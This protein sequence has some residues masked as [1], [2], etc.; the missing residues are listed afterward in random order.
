MTADHRPE[1]V[2]ARLG[3][4]LPEVAPD[5]YYANYRRSAAGPIHLSGQLPSVDGEVRTLG[6]LGKEV[7]V[8]TARE[9]MKI[10]TINALAVAAEA[11]GGLDNL[12][13]LQL[14]VFVASTP[15]FKGQSDVADAGSA[16]LVEI[17]GEHGRH[18]RTAF[19]VSSLPRT[20]PLEVQLIVEARS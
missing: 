5:S 3:I 17:L 9:L 4:E 12:R 20:S 16:L 8:E 6:S 2:L 19:G 7:D 14:L 15:D 11:V 18:A 10:A 1:E 13:I